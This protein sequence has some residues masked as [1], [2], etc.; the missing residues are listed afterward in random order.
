MKKLFFAAVVILPL[1]AVSCSKSSSS[2]GSSSVKAVDIG[3]SVKWSDRNLG[4]RSVGD[5]GDYYAWGETTTKATFTVE[6]YKWVKNG[7][8]QY[9]GIEEEGSPA[10]LRPEDDAARV[11]LGKNWRMPTKENIQE[12]VSTYTNPNYQWTWTRVGGHMGFEIKYLQNGNSIFLPASGL[13]DNA[14][15]RYVEAYGYYL[16]DELVMDADFLSY[17]YGLNMEQQHGPGLYR[18]L[19]RTEGNSIRPVAD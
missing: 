3:L 12:L 17:I 4:A 6:N 18:T 7:M 10:F 8:Y 9:Y 1:L 13:V 15:Y 16:S 11:R 2:N 19:R 5:L 14:T